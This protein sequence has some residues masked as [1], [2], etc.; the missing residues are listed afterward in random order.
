IF[1]CG[2]GI[3]RSSD[4][5]DTWVHL[6][7][8]PQVEELCLN[9]NG[10]LFAGTHDQGLFYSTDEGNNWAASTNGLT[11]IHVYSMVVNSAGFIFAGGQGGGVFRSTDKGNE[12]VAL[13]VLAVPANSPY[14]AL[15]PDNYIYAVGPDV[16]Y[17]SDNGETWIKSNSTPPSLWSLA[18]N[19]KGYL[20]AGTY[21]Q[22]VYRS[23]DKGNS[24]QEINNG[25][26]E[27]FVPSI[28]AISS[29]DIFAG[30]GSGVFRS[31]DDGNNW[32]PIGLSGNYIYSL[33]VSSGGDIF[34]GSGEM[35][36]FPTETARIFR[37]SINNIS[38][39]IVKEVDS[40][41]F[42][43]LTV[44]T[45][46]YVY[47]GSLFKGMFSSTDNGNTWSK[48]NEG[49]SNPNVL[50]LA[51]DSSGYL[52]AGTFGG[53]F[54][55]NSSTISDS[56]VLFLSQDSSKIYNGNTMMEIKWISSHIEKIKLEYT[57]DGTGWNT[58]V[59][60]FPA[61]RENYKWL[62]P[63]RSSQLCKIR[64]SDA[65]N[66]LLYDVSDEYFSITS[67][68]DEYPDQI[69]ES[70]ELFQNYPNPFNPSTIISF[71]I[72]SP[73]FVTLKV[74]DVLGR[75]IATLI[76]EEKPNG[77]YKV[78]FNGSSLSSGIYLY[79]LKAGKFLETKKLI[80]MK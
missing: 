41:A 43:A 45:K 16:Y 22:G 53:V 57:E 77:V 39:T 33:A 11:D 19:I 31:T 32:Q 60:G 40:S 61:F 3:F 75:E 49:L 29:G 7:E 4:D 62:I 58:I 55:S 15:T 78:Q 24:W 70:F 38:W 18:A 47:A 48:I 20:F 25:L 66:P 46:G 5:G 68:L 59:L 34:A 42:L 74:Y 71:S 36:L 52:Y 1:S 27:R 79:N 64:I 9:N 14:L 23:T 2:N 76:N 73:E 37:S 21:G 56:S 44:N 54:R 69:S 12:W 72:P 28:A 6:N 80:L 50:S 8:M 30:T 13:N 26:T 10:Y 17:S 67:V 65:Q 51:A 63:D 35:T